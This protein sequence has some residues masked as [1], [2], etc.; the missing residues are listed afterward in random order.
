MKKNIIFYLMVMLLIGGCMDNKTSSGK[1]T[2]A[3]SETTLELAIFAGGCFWCMEQPFETLEGVESV[4]SGYI[5]GEKKNPT[6]KKVNS[7]DTGH[8][9]AIEISFDSQKLSYEKLL[10]TFWKQINPTD[11]GGQ[12]ADRGFQ[13]TTGIFYLNDEQ[14]EIAEKSRNG[15]ERSGK[16]EIPIVTEIIKATEFYPA[17]DYHQDYYKTNPTRYKTYKKYSGREQYLKKVWKNSLDPDKTI[18]DKFLKPSDKELKQR[19][20]NLQ[21]DVTQKDSTEPPFNNEYWDNKEEGIYVDIVTGEPLFSSID[22]FVSG[23]G[24]PSYIKPLVPENIIEKKDASLGIIR[25][26][27]RSRY[28]DSHL[29][30]LFNDG[31]PPT[32]LRYCINSASLKFV[33]LERLNEEGYGEFKDLFTDSK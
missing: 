15:L 7:G 27:I 18:S 20:T 17:E 30:H 21:Y 13:Y 16:F 3:V 31:P 8:R 32:G 10:D 6:Y 19:L 12:F 14:K 2:K 9:E 4:I 23:T 28:G 24:W 22:K 26:E 1:E 29:G 25:T 33:P 11:S 5:G